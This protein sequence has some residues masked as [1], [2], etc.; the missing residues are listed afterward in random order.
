MP[1]PA[2]APSGEITGDEAMADT[3]TILDNRTEKDLELPIIYGTYPEYG[4]AIG[5]QFDV[6]SIGARFKYANFD[7]FDLI[8]AG[9]DFGFLVKKVPFVAPYARFGLYY[10]TTKGGTVIPLLDTVVETG[11]SVVRSHV[12][13]ARIE[14]Q[15]VTVLRLAAI[16]SIDREFD[17]LGAG[18]GSARVNAGKRSISLNLKSAAGQRAAQALVYSRF[19]MKRETLE[20]P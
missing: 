1:K 11:A 9:V 15:R 19:G 13:G 14:L 3:V 16:T 2:T 18:I 20:A 4:A 8:T 12:S 17:G 10:N 7:P 5:A 6:F